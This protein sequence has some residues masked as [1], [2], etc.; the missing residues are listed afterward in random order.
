MNSPHIEHILTELQQNNEEARQFLHGLTEAQMNWVPEPGTWSVAQCLEHLT[1]ANSEFRPY[2][3]QAIAKARQ[4]PAT[5]APYRMTLMGGML[6]RAMQQE[7][8]RK[9]KAPKKFQPLP[10]PPP[11]ALVRFLGAQRHIAS[12]AE[13]AQGADITVKMRSPA[14]PF[15]RYSL[16]DAFELIVVHNRRH[17]RQA[18]RV[19]ERQDFPRLAN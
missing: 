15:V 12:L 11:G 2:L 19:T 9:Y 14:T 4:R 1:V 5:T 3:E 13:R 6:I 16:A 7:G 17:L 8:G 10:E 18:R